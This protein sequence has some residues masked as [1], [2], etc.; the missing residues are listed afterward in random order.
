MPNFGTRTN[1]P[2]HQPEP[3]TKKIDLCSAT[4]SSFTDIRQALQ[5]QNP[6]PGSCKPLDQVLDTPD[7]KW[8]ELLQRNPQNYLDQWNKLSTHARDVY[9]NHST[10][11]GYPVDRNNRGPSV[12]TPPIIECLIK[13]SEIVQGNGSV[14]PTNNDGPRVVVELLVNPNGKPKK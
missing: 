8:G 10:Q 1:P 2:G 5:Q 12:L 4:L 3:L 14:Q 13:H 9:A 7:Y 6:P 11:R